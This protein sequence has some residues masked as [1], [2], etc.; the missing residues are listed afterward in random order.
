MVNWKTTVGGIIAGTILIL[1]VV[2]NSYKN[3]VPI[4]WYQIA[5]AFA[6]VVL[7]ALMKD[8][9]VTGGT[10][11]TLPKQVKQFAEKLD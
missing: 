4:D 5:F 8:F 6:I 9:D 7:S 2:A 10:R 3:H 1:K 11:A